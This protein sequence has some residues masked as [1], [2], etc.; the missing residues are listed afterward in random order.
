MFDKIF[1]HKKS[2]TEDLLRY[3]K[4]SYGLYNDYLIMYK[5][6][7]LESVN[8]NIITH[9]QYMNI[10]EKYENKLIDYINNNLNQNRS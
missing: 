6:S 9:K 4:I 8:E 2:E 7:L 5:E 10:C 1:K 3:Y